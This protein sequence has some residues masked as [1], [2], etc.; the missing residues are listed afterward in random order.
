MQLRYILQVLA[1]PLKQAGKQLVNI[2]SVIKA[3]ILLQELIASRLKFIL[4][5]DDASVLKF[6][7]SSPK[8]ILYMQRHCR[9][10]T[11][12]SLMIFILHV[13]G[14]NSCTKHNYKPPVRLK[15]IFKCTKGSC[16]CIR[17]MFLQQIWDYFPLN[18][19]HCSILLQK[20][21]YQRTTKHTLLLYNLS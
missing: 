9:R 15:K 17:A 2:T 11:K 14:G 21:L 16:G 18:H 7:A 20:A 4:F 10:I 13:I 8:V 5:N 19:M 12:T 6:N 1:R 3:A